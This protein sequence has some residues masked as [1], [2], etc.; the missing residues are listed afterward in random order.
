M[1]TIRL[2]I[3][4]LLLF[5]SF[6]VLGAACMDRNK[7]R[8]LNSSYNASNKSCVCAP[9]Y[10]GTISGNGDNGF[11]GACTF[12]K[13][14]TGVSPAAW[15]VP[16]VAIGFASVATGGYY[17][18][19]TSATSVTS[20][21]SSVARVNTKILEKT[22]IELMDNER[23]AYLDPEEQN[24]SASEIN[25]I[26]SDFNP[27]N[28]LGVK[29]SPNMISGGYSLEKPIDELSV[30]SYY[31]PHDE[32]SAG[33]FD[34]TVGSPLSNDGTGGN[35]GGNDYIYNTIQKNHHKEWNLRVENYSDAVISLD[36][37]SSQVK[38]AKENILEEIKLNAASNGEEAKIGGYF[39]SQAVS[40]PG[41][42]DIIEANA[43]IR[44]PKYRDIGRW[45]RARIR[46]RR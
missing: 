20:T 40:N 14:S 30:E 42:A 25:N 24:A 15:V 11:R 37:L 3:L 18:Y 45:N 10:N 43:I 1:G 38:D 8:I 6:N 22:I 35:T 46:R 17:I 5:S 31:V 27:A 26:R 19:K 36:G 23:L 39:E 7:D 21:H 2:S 4:S 29:V 44:D 33:L 9:G 41:I 34:S 28:P 12:V 16:I 13:A 32:F